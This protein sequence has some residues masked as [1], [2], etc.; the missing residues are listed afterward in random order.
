MIDKIV[1]SV[2][3]ALD[4]I[5]DG[6]VVL[7]GGFGA[8]GQA[9]GLLEG[10]LAQGARDLTIVANNAGTGEGGLARL[11]GAG[12]VRRMVCSFPRGGA[13]VSVFE[14]FYKA[15][16]IRA[17]GAGIPAFFTPT[18]V[19]TVIAEGKEH[20]E[21]NGR[22]VV[23][24]YALPGDV[25]LVEAWEADRWGNLVYRASA[26]NFNPLMAMAAK[27][28]IV[29]ANHLRELGTL[30][31]EMIATPGIFV[32]RVVHVAATEASS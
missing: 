4:G 26:R 8:V 9:N 13:G 1:S 16:R 12:R 10:L 23:L 32:D 20:R 6:S 31:P 21:I 7:L 24:E 15:G 11:I 19:G 29:Q 25:A 17:A 30:S 2:A 22:T 18:S 14:Q 5:A 28:T 3:A 27:R